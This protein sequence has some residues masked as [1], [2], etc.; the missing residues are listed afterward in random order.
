MKQYRIPDHPLFPGKSN[1]PRTPMNTFGI[2]SA[3]NSP[4]NKNKVIPRFKANIA[5]DQWGPIIQKDA[6]SFFI[7]EHHKRVESMDKALSYRKDLET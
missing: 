4:Q 3:Q 7:E 2:E 6:Q 5:M 1:S